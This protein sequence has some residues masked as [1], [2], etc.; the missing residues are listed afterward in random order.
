MNC[1]AMKAC[2]SSSLSAIDAANVTIV[3]NGELSCYD[4]NFFCPINDNTLC[5][6]SCDP[7]NYGACGAMEVHV[8][9]VSKVDFAHVDCGTTNSRNTCDG[10]NY[11]CGSDATNSTLIYK[12][13][14]M[15]L[16]HVI[17]LLTKIATSPPPCI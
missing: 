1:G 3:C 12:N 2:Y 16:N 7:T 15:L 9:D 8:A 10:T 4:L 13:K 11:I 5:D 14:G 17:D 6:I